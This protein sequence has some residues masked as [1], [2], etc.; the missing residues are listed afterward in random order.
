M[1]WKAGLRHSAGTN[2]AE[3]ERQA[4]RHQWLVCSFVDAAC[5][6]DIP[7]SQRSAK[8]QGRPCKG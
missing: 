6:R 7:W 4:G 2:P 5:S 1:Q 3:W 8:K